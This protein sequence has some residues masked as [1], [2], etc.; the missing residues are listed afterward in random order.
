L[1]EPQETS[2][3][4]VPF[5]SSKEL[6]QSLSSDNVEVLYASLVR[7]K[8]QLR[9]FNSNPSAS[10][11]ELETQ[12]RTIYEYIEKSP[13]FSELFAIWDYQL[14]VSCLSSGNLWNKRIWLNHAKD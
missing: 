1:K 11:T 7:L 13:E 10:T 12:R 6:V 2:F 14:T 9:P 8:R 4:S 3:S 5:Q